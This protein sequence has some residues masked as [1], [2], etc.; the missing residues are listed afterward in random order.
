[1]EIALAIEAADANTKAFKGTSSPPIYK[2]SDP[3]T[4]PTPTDRKIMCTAV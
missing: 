2:V 1:M 4:P 3:P